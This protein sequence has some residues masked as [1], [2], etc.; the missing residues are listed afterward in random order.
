MGR[1][2]H[3]QSQDTVPKRAHFG[4][5]LNRWRLAIG[6][7]ALVIVILVS[8][9]IAAENR[10][11]R[12]ALSHAPSLTADKM[13]ELSPGEVYIVEGQISEQT[14]PVVGRLAVACEE[15]YWSDDEG[16]GWDI[17]NELGN[18]VWIQLAPELEVPVGIADPCPQGSAQMYQDPNNSGRRWQGYAIGQ[19]ITAIAVLAAAEP[20]QLQAEEHR[21]GSRASYKRFLELARIENSV[22]AGLLLLISLVVMLWP[23]KR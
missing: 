12:L 7:L 6:G 20:L 18:T 3:R 5:K 19:N 22:I 13:S 8:G 23:A 11:S 16:S 4:W 14:K 9:M 17:E 2:T 15:V 21:S 10:Q 1:Q